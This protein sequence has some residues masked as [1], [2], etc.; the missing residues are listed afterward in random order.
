MIPTLVIWLLKKFWPYI[1]ENKYKGEYKKASKTIVIIIIALFF[2][3]RLNAQQQL[4]QYYVFYK[5]N[6]IGKMILK[7]T[8]KNDL[9]TIEIASN[10]HMRIIKAINVNVREDYY[11]NSGQ[12]IHSSIWRQVNG[13]EKINRQTD[14]YG[15]LY[16]LTTEGKKSILKEET[17][18]YNLTKLYLS[19]PVNIQQVYSDN[20]QQFLSIINI[21]NHSYK[22]QLPGNDYNI[23]SYENGICKSI[24]VH[25]TFYTIQMKLAE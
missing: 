24:E 21:G 25:N 20:F 18:S 19:E 8:K 2:S 4:S 23:Y 15:N 5:G 1:K 7:Q 9:L 22:L 3:I 10:I 13:T 12:L 6:N 17:I 14:F 16:H 11:Y